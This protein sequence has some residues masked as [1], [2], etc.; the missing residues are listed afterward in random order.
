MR[1]IR[2]CPVKRL[3]I[4]RCLETIIQE[5]SIVPRTLL[6]LA[7]RSEHDIKVMYFQYYITLICKTCHATIRDDIIYNGCLCG[8]GRMVVDISSTHGYRHLQVGI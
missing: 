2:T 8:R 5:L 4:D 3:V 1:A 6:K 7:L